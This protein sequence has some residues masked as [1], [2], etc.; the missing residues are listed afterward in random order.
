MGL[1]TLSAMDQ[2][3]NKACAALSSIPYDV[4]CNKIKQSAAQIDSAEYA[5]HFWGTFDNQ[6]FI[7]TLA[8]MGRYATKKL[9]VLE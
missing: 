6:L 8:S 2:I 4:L 7:L 3:S 9:L 5:Q 1:T